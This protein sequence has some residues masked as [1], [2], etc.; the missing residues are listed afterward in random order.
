MRP[1]AGEAA[2]AGSRAQA[3]RMADAAL[4]F[5]IGRGSGRC[6]CSRAPLVIM[7]VIIGRT[8]REGGGGERKE[9][10]LDEESEVTF[11]KFRITSDVSII[12]H[13]FITRL[14]R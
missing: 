1:A 11:L 6:M 13:L 12:P 8:D 7:R 3:K 9:E 10:A 5:H 14:G 2:L 4:T